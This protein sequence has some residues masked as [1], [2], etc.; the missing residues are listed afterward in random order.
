MTITIDY[1]VFEHSFTQIANKL[2]T[3][4]RLSKYHRLLAV[5]LN[6][7]NM[8]INRAT[9]N[10]NMLLISKK[11]LRYVLDFCIE[12]NLD[13][14]FRGLRELGIVSTF[15]KQGG[16][17][18]TYSVTLAENL[19]HNPFVILDMTEKQVIKDCTVLVN[20]VSKDYFGD[21][22]KFVENAVKSVEAEYV[23]KIKAGIE[24]LEEYKAYLKTVI[25]EAGLGTFDDTDN[26]SSD[27]LS[28][29]KGDVQ[30]V[31]ESVYIVFCDKY[32]DSKGI[33]HPVN[34]RT[35]I[36]QISKVFEYCGGDKDM[37][38]GFVDKFFD[39]YSVKDE[40]TTALFANDG[41]LSDIRAFVEEGTKPRVFGVEQYKPDAVKKSEQAR[42]AVQVNQGMDKEA[43]LRKLRGEV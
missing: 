22:L 28:G 5:M 14:L 40:P 13:K 26:Q 35:A 31:M 19:E 2:L 37:V 27:T 42:E 24:S 43:M 33:S 15:S 7:R 4:N 6:L 36:K 16:I 18:G 9:P 21:F 38:L 17:D 12:D 3:C 41:I 30:S 11:E 20:N 23:V 10:P 1:I 8:R 32:K 25:V 29:N 34:K 39:F